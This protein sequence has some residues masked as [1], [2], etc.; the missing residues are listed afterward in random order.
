MSLTTENIFRSRSSPESAS[1]FI[2]DES[3]ETQTAGRCDLF[4][5]VEP[6]GIQLALKEL[7]ENCFLALEC[8]PADPKKTETQWTEVFEKISA[9]SKLLRKYEFARVTVSISTPY[10][11]LV[12][13][14]LFR[15]GDE[16]GYL[17]FNFPV[18]QDMTV[19]ATP[20]PFF[21]LYSVFAIPT[22]LVTELNHLFEDP[23]IVHHS[24]ALLESMS[25]FARTHQER[26]LFLN[27]YGND[28]DAIVTDGKNLI[29]MNSFS[30]KGI[31]DTLYFVLFLC[32]Q[33]DMNPETIDVR[34]AGN[35]EK[36]SA[37]Y[38]LLFRYIRNLSFSTRP[39]P[40]EYSYGFKDL[41]SQFFHPLFSLA[42]CES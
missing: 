41:P 34:L 39:G 28:M 38:K 14:G 13:D 17:Q 35:I 37:L 31:E 36:E 1:I 30:C 10:Y 21:Q 19:Y 4:V 5:S 42:L 40:A 24:R 12:P 11:T 22:S 3:L 26:Q 6:G 16:Q 8:F 7:K 9:Q 18:E 25:M 2:L 33:L 23:E 29:L 32:E 15:K 27:F 20:V